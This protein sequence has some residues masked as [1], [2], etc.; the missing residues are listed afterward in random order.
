VGDLDGDGTMSVA[1]ANREGYLYVWTT[2][3]KVT[4]RVDW[5]SF[6]HDDHNS[7]NFGN[8]IGFGVGPSVGGGGG[9]CDAGGARD[10]G[11]SLLLMGLVAIALRR[12]RRRA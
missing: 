7:G 11:S 1:V 8:P 5:A 12:R 10:T 2:E 9:C 3:G 4:G 6:H